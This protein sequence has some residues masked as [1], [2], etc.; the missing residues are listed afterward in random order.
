MIDWDEHWPVIL[1]D[2]VLWAMLVVIAVSDLMDDD[3]DKD[4]RK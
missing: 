1:L 2:V 4:K 3:N